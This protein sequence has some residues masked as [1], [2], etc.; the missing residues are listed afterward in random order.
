MSGEA[1]FEIAKNAEKPFTVK[2]SK[3]NINVTGT[4][5]NVKAYPESEVFEAVLAEGSIELQLNN[6]NNQK[7]DL[8]PG[9]KVIYHEDNKG[10]TIENV[11]ADFFTS[12]RNGEILFKDATLNDLIKELERI[13]DIKFH[14]RDPELGEFRFRG[15]FSYT[16]NLID[17]LEKIKRTANIDYLIENKEVWLSKK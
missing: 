1:Y 5:F 15:M 12:W 4:S 10:I 8:V 6:Q 13:Y 11:D 2:T 16:N 9:E 3:A 7:L 14:L 17:A